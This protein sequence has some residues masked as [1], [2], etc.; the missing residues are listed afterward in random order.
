MGELVE[1]YERPLEEHEGAAGDEPDACKE[2]P[3]GVFTQIEL[4][5]A[6]VMHF[7]D[8]IELPELN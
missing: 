6:N 8:G 2:E 5:A 7:L 3:E 1:V 4:Q